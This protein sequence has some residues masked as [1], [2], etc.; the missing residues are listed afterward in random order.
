MSGMEIP[1]PA[2]Q[3]DSTSLAVADKNGHDGSRKKVACD[4]NPNQGFAKL[5]TQN[6]IQSVSDSLSDKTNPKEI[7]QFNGTNHEVQGPVLPESRQFTD[8]VPVIVCGVQKNGE[9]HEINIYA[10]NAKQVNIELKDCDIVISGDH[11]TAV[12][13]NF[14]CRNNH[15]KCMTP[16]DSASSHAVVS[17]GPSTS[18]CPKSNVS[19]NS[20]GKREQQ[21][22]PR[23]VKTE[24]VRKMKVSNSSRV[25]KRLDVSGVDMRTFKLDVAHGNP[26]RMMNSWV[27]SIISH[28]LRESSE[29]ENYEE[30]KALLE[31]AKKLVKEDFANCS[32][33]LLA[34]LELIGNG[35]EESRI[36][37]TEARFVLAEFYSI[38][39]KHNSALE[40]LMVIEQ[41]SCLEEQKSRIF[42]KIAETFVK[43]GQECPRGKTENCEVLE[44]AN[45][46][47][48]KALNHSM[49]TSTQE[50]LDINHAC[51]IGMAKL[52]LRSEEPL[53]S[54][55]EV[56]SEEDF[57]K[58]EQHIQHLESERAG[59]CPLM[60]CRFFLL[61][62]YFQYY[63]RN[64][65]MAL[66]EAVKAKE[67]SERWHL[68]KE[69]ALVTKAIFIVSQSLPQKRP[70]HDGLLFLNQIVGQNPSADNEDFDLE[71]CEQLNLVAIDSD[72]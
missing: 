30:I 49:K 41:E 71:G 64:Y 26:E 42:L 36:L 46:H 51:H 10:Q 12:I 63:Y 47:F 23:K 37:T 69:H 61:K 19:S 58:A 39:G 32:N 8:T 20:C 11:N 57:K 29:L 55:S 9:K 68:E 18:T 15:C 2:K 25:R 50:Q 60:K 33:N 17:D 52:L 43:I 70:A 21:S 31:A 45:K 3:T 66:A 13:R 27:Q 59:F 62:A 14:V 48:E 6:E 4:V 7:R 5:T 16:V 67:T 40:Q 54:R 24:K 28:L 22:K 53:T 38:K 65:V 1:E 72:I 44:K 56:P 34:A 35:L